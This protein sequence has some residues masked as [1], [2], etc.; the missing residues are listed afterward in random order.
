M[1]FGSFDRAEA[2][3]VPGADD[4]AKL[5]DQLQLLG[6]IVAPVVVDA[7]HDGAL[8]ALGR[9]DELKQFAGGL[10]V[11]AAVAEAVTPE[12]DHGLAAVSDVRRGFEDLHVVD[13]AFPVLLD[14]VHFFAVEPAVVHDREAP[15][16]GVGRLAGVHQHRV[17]AQV[18]VA[19][20]FVG[21]DLAGEALDPDAVNAV[22]LH[23]LEVSHHGVAIR[24][25]KDRGGLAIGV[26]EVGVELFV[27]AQLGHVGPHVNGRPRRVVID[28]AP[29]GKAHIEAVA[30]GHEPALIPRHHRPVDRCDR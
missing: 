9:L 13:Q 21:V 24:R 30:L 26:F 7:E 28:I 18:V 11:E 2:A 16:V 19:F 4:L 25:A 6:A 29:V 10:G 23:P 27:F 17:G 22:F 20:G 12:G 15:A 1:I 8:A 3:D 5:F 14:L